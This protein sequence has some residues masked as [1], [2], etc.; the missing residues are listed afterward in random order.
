[1]AKD[2]VVGIEVP[3]RNT[4]A[5][6]VQKII[7]EYGCHIHARLGLHEVKGKTCVSKGLIIIHMLCDENSCSKMLSKLRKLKG[8]K[9]KK[10]SF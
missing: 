2:I 7:S 6:E 5:L 3:D 8:I 9:A 1:M 10:M 4:H